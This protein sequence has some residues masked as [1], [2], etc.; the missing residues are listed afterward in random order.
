VSTIAQTT[1]ET[2]YLDNG[3]GKLVGYNAQDDMVSGYRTYIIPLR[4]FLGIAS[5]EDLMPPQL[6]DGAT[7][8]IHLKNINSAVCRVSDDIGPSD[9]TLPLDSANASIR[10]C[11]LVT[12]SYLFDNKLHDLIQREYETGGLVVRYSSWTNTRHPVSGVSQNL[13]F[14]IRQ[15]ATR[16]TKLIAKMTTTAAEQHLQG[17]NDNYRAREGTYLFSSLQAKHA[18]KYIPDRAMT[19]VEE[20]QFAWLSA[21]HKA[22]GGCTAVARTFMDEFAT[23]NAF[24]VDLNRGISKK[25]TSG[26]TVSTKYPLRLELAVGALQKPITSDKFLNTQLE[27]EF[28][29]QRYIDT[30][31]EHERVVIASPTGMRVLH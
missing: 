24:V 29:W 28:T 12:D 10:G 6:I 4:H 14:S 5:A 15:S 25:G 20:A 2:D 17:Y 16:A 18:D 30:F 9:I 23:R 3:A 1:Y 11:T 19:T 13:S 7:L 22:S 27:S 21:F 26:V 8:E 31:L